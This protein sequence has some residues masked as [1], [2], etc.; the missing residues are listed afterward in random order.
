MATE[1]D[2]VLQKE[3]DELKKERRGLEKQALKSIH[4]LLASEETPDTKQT[5]KHEIKKEMKGALKT[6]KLAIREKAKLV[7]AE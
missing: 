1:K 6:T 5:R 7:G 4:T 2:I 3:I